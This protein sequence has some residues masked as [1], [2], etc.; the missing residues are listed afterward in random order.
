MGSTVLTCVQQRHTHSIKTRVSLFHACVWAAVKSHQ[1]VH[2]S[3][4]PAPHVT[5]GPPESFQY[6]RSWSTS[7]VVANLDV[8]LSQTMHGA[9]MAGII[10]LRWGMFLQPTIHAGALLCVR[11]HQQH[12]ALTRMLYLCSCLV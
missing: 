9:S 1:Q 10:M 11:T 2:S 3:L 8:S 6:G 12:Q 4:T 5:S 7:C